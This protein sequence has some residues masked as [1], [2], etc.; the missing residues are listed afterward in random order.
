MINLG[1]FEDTMWPDRWTAPTSD[2][3][4]SSQFEHTMVV[5]DK[6][7]ELLTDYEDGVPFYDSLF[8]LRKRKI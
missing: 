2:G 3:K 5:T 8:F 6:G 1:G 7:V 4:R